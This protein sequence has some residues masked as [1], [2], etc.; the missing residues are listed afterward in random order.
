MLETLTAGERC[1]CDLQ[2]I[3]GSDLS[4]ISKHLALM[5]VAGLVADRRQGLQVFYWLRVPCVMSFLDWSM[6]CAPVRRIPP[7]RPLGEGMPAEGCETSRVAPHEHRGFDGRAR[8]QSGS[9]APRGS[10]AVTRPRASRAT[11]QHPSTSSRRR[12][13]PR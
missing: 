6:R 1:V 8:Q 5:R 2:R 7:V 12:C 4:T 9:V 10:T 13:R 3:V 11:L